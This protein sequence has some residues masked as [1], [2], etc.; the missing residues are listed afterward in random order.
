ML[1][2]ERAIL[3]IDMD[4]F[5]VNVHL[6]DHPEDAGIPLAVG[7]RPEHRGV[8]ASASYEARRLGIRSAMPMKTAVRLCPKLRI[9]SADWERIRHW[10]RQIMS[11]LEEVGPTEQISV[12]EAF[13]DVSAHVDPAQ[14]AITLRERIKAES[15]LPASVGLATSKLVAKVASDFD[16]P[17]GCTIVAPQ[18][19]TAF[20][21]PLSVRVIWGIGQR[22]GERLAEINV[23]TCA[24]LVETPLNI[25]QSVVGNQAEAIQRRAQGIDNRPVITDY[26]VAKSISQEWTFSQDIA[27]KESLAQ[28]LRQMCERV[29]ESLEKRKLTAR[30]VT[31]KFRWEDFTTMTRQRSLIRPISAPD[32]ICQVAEAIWLENWE[33]NRPMRLLGVGVSNIS[34]TSQPTQ[35]HFNF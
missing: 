28:K 17:E 13:V 22:T 33:E 24:D 7:G 10:S 27:E 35:L 12:D 21:A 19:E 14:T 1:T 8:V 4:A 32:D 6:L 25:L 23:K 2:W 9:V 18:E 31:V 15:G 5:Y 26:G 29:S 30:T 11:L 3:H 16:K 20:L 34:D